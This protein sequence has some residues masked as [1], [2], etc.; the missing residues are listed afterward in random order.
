MAR[1]IRTRLVQKE[2][3]VGVPHEKD[4]GTLANRD[5]RGQGEG[6]LAKV[7]SEFGSQHYKAPL[8][9]RKIGSIYGK[10]ILK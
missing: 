7:K 1:K 2:H 5:F 3:F 10:T 6:H 8:L 4:F 9:Q